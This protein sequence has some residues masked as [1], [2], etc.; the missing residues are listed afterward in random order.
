MAMP[1]SRGSA[2][3]SILARA[4]AFLTQARA[5]IISGNWESGV[6]EIWKLFMAR[7][8]CTP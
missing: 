2:C 7:K 4:Q 3:N 5:Q 1:I 6:P 8:V